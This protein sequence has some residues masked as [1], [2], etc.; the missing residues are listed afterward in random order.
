MQAVKILLTSI[1]ST[2]VVLEDNIQR[3]PT[4]E[5]RLVAGR[6]LEGLKKTLTAI[7]L[8]KKIREQ[9]PTIE[10]GVGR[11]DDP[12]ENIEGRIE[13]LERWLGIESQGEDPLEN[14]SHRAL[15]IDLQA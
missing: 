7:Y 11:V 10:W 15:H 1:F 12:L 14:A 13:A 8:D 5:F 3:Y 9:A 2:L 4:D 6:I